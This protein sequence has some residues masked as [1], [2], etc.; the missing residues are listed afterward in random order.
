[1]KL[2]EE[3][4]SQAISEMDQKTG[5]VVNTDE[6]IQLAKIY[7]SW[8]KLCEL[9][10]RDSIEII[11]SKSEM[12]IGFLDRERS[13][14]QY[15]YRQLPKNILNEKYKKILDELK[16]EYDKFTPNFQFNIKILRQLENVEE[17]LNTLQTKGV[18]KALEVFNIFLIFLFKLKRIFFQ[19]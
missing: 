11:N 16:L 1:M 9:I 14:R 4:L 18:C 17:V 5:N 19:I 15:A 2:I 12:L 7:K 10:I 3:I 13:D 8:E 6:L